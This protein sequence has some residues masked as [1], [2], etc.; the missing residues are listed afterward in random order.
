MR[1]PR[2]TSLLTGIN[3]S[4]RA[5]RKR[6]VPPESY[7]DQV[8][9][10]YAEVWFPTGG[11]VW[12]AI[13]HCTTCNYGAP[14]TVDPDTMVRAVEIAVA[15]LAPTTETLWV[16]AFDTLQEREV[17]AAA[18][19]RIFQALSEVPAHTILTETHPA[20]LRAPAL[21]ECVAALGDR[22]LGIQLGVE[23]MDEF[24]RYAC[25]NKPF[26]NNQ[27]AHAVHTIH[28]QGAYA[29]GNLIVGIPFLNRSE[30]VQGTIDSICA[31]AA[32]GFD[33]IVLFPNHVKEHT[34]AYLLAEAGRYTPPDL[35]TMRDVL[36]GVPAELI[37]RVHLAWLDLKPHPGAATVVFEPSQL[38][39]DERRGLLDTFNLHRD[40]AALDAAMA[41]PR[42]EPGAD[43]DSGAD[44]I[45]RLIDNYQ[46]L[47]DNYGE[48]NWWLTNSAAVQAELQAGYRDTSNTLVS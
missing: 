12:D 21:A 1:M 5:N 17:P 39:M 30:V 16:S 44:L 7:F 4:V 3:T 37:D 33:N 27:L 19:R 34:I 10:T 14:T 48:L 28:E 13:G 36:V 25:V 26:S 24:V 22:R 20:S 9:A 38:A 15:Q 6:F 31:A 41:L 46:W 8:S 47:A 42:P 43:N 2:T 23:T 40:R 35:W 18:R 45:T 29:W 32:L 11:C